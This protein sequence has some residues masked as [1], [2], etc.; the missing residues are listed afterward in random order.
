MRT[1]HIFIIMVIMASLAMTGNVNAKLQDFWVGGSIGQFSPK[2]QIFK[3]LYGSGMQWRIEVGADILNWLSIWADAVNSKMTGHL[4]V[5]NEESKLTMSFLN[6]GIRFRFPIK[7]FIPYVG[8]GAGIIRFKEV[9][10][11]GEAR[12]KDGNFV[13]EAGVFWKLNK[14]FS[15]YGRVVYNWCQVRTEIIKVK[16]GGV[17]ASLGVNFYF[18]KLFKEKK[19][20]V[21]EW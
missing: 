4:T 2:E 8:G 18:G 14:V 12:D 15:V 21:W 20:K 9:N 10:P 17:S 6:M 16:I 3:D 13:G 5:T 7:N 19:P 1:K 11:I